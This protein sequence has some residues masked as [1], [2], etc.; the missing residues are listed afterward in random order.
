M[1]HSSLSW[2]L[3]SLSDIERQVLCDKV[4]SLIMKILVEM[5]VHVTP[6]DLAE[7]RR[8]QLAI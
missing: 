6:S 5:I 3:R 7:K 4:V 2:C 1:Q 8:N